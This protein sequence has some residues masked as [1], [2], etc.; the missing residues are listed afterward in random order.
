MTCL[1]E[2]HWLSLGI[3]W[4]LYITVDRKLGHGQWELSTGHPIIYC[5]LCG[6]RLPEHPG[7]ATIEGTMVQ[8]APCLGM[9][10]PVGAHNA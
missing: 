1:T 7:V 2:Q 10:G 3:R 9:A 6:E 4:V 5:P 8:S